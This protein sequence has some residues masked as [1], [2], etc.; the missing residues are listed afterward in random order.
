MPLVIEGS[1]IGLLV[2]GNKKNSG[3]YSIEEIRNLEKILVI[4]A[5]AI[6]RYALYKKQESFAFIL[7]KEV[8]KATKELKN[9]NK[10]LIEKSQQENDMLDVLGHE[11]RTP[12]SIV[13]NAVDFMIG[14][15]KTDKLSK[16]QL[17][18]YLKMSQENLYREIKLLEIMLS[19]T[20][21]D[22][23]KLNLS[24][25]K[26]D[27]IDVVNDTLL[28]LKEKAKIKNIKLFFKH[29]SKVFVLADRTRIQE[30]TDNLIENAIKYTNVGSV[31]V[32]LTEVEDYYC[33][34]VKDTG[35]GISKED[36]NNIGKKFFRANQYVESSNSNNIPIVRPGGTGLGLYVTLHLIRAMDGKIEINSELGKGSNFKVYFK[37][38]HEK[39]PSSK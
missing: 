20:K 16:P 33:L 17:T 1:V 34:S 22:N 25:E 26:V 30:I 14:L 11:L 28:G 3:Y 7:Q 21:I 29:D 8:N 23:K 31:S 4:L 6:N 32:S 2:F 37:K 10:L 18:K 24:I 13:R 36:L 27:F 39:I 35:I 19:S 12:L 5:I 9:K 38:F 15:E